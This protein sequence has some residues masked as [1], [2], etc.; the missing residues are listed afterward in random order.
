MDQVA[1]P[2]PG[3]LFNV[4]A[5]MIC[6]QFVWSW[7]QLNHQSV[8]A[9]LEDWARGRRQQQQS[10]T[11]KW[12][13]CARMGQA[14]KVGENWEKTIELKGIWQNNSKVGSHHWLSLIIIDNHWSMIAI[15]CKLQFPQPDYWPHHSPDF[16]IVFG[17]M[18]RPFSSC[19]IGKTWGTIKQV[20][21]QTDKCQRISIL[22]L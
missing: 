7:T 13:E 5:C 20:N 9:M 14:S 18:I 12:R 17:I 15:D 19:E 6:C 10:V 4:I 8:E 22:L 3:Q 11:L 1:C 21:K 16:R 2:H